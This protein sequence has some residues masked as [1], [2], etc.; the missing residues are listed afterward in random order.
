MRV[1]RPLLFAAEAAGA[2][3]APLLHAARLEP[4]ALGDVGRTISRQELYR[5]LDGIVEQTRDPAFGLHCLQRLTPQAFNPITGLVFHAPDLR[6]SMKALQK[7]LSLLAHDA[8]ISLDESEDRAVVRCD[9]LP[10]APPLARRFAVEMF[11]AGLYRRVR[12]FCRQASFDRLAFAHEAP[13][14][15][16]EYSRV[17]RGPVCFDQPFSGLVFDRAL[18]DARSPHEDPELHAALSSF[19]ERKLETQAR[20]TSYAV[21]VHL[22]VLRHPRPRHADMRGIART[23]DLS[24]R[25]LRRRLAGEGTTFAKVA[26]AA[27]AEAAKRSLA[28]DRLSIQETAFE[29]GF[30][31]RAAFHR[32]FKRWTGMTPQEFCERQGC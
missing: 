20:S 2:A 18:L 23:L 17:F 1:V 11:V 24:E 13:T 16:D 15:R 7:F 8:S 25:S 9:V 32:A 29:L 30:A 6:E 5:L 14:Y 26:D 28:D 12:I 31:D 27:L 21:R 19:G 4:D 3:R 10:D 22:A